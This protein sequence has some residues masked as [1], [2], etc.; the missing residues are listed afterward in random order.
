ML[1][2]DKPNFVSLMSNI[3]ELYKDKL[4]VARLEI[5]WRCLQHYSIETLRKA[6]DAHVLNPDQGQFMPK[7]ADIVRLLEG[8]NITKALQAFNKVKRAVEQVGS[9]SSI[10]F[11]DP[12]THVVI[13][14]MGGWM[15]LCKLYDKEFS[16][17]SL[18]F[19]KL[20][21]RYVHQKPFRHPKQLTG[22]MDGVNLRNGY[23][24]KPPVFFGDQ[25][26]AMK[27]YQE[28]EEKNTTIEYQPTNLLSK[29]T[30]EK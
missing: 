1:P 22:T 2:E 12:I 5:Y 25:E 8:G 4:S 28:G 19:Q 30:E 21:V 20:Y 29:H 14:Q 17:K 6:L 23:L 13:E 3:A 15:Q 26:L 10:V 11:D 27:V 7:P 24:T 16:F 18:D 9:Y